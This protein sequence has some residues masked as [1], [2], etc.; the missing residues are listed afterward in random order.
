MQSQAIIGHAAP[1]LEISAWVQGEAT[2]LHDLHGKVVLVEV[3]Q[4][5]CTG[6]FVH[7]LPEV[8]HLHKTY[9]QQGLHV[10]GLATAFENFDINTLENLKRLVKTG[11]LTG[12]PLRQLGAAGQLQGDKLDYA[13]PFPIAMDLLSENRETV[14]D[15]AIQRFIDSQLADYADLP[16]DR[17][18]LIWTRASDY[19]HS[20][21]HHAHT[22]E[23][24]G[25]QG[26]PSS[27]VID[28]KGVLRNVS[29]GR[30][31]HL[32]ALIMPL[33]NA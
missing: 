27:I 23:R 24:Y 7:A 16:A 30:A 32:E 21:S 22:F 28:R 6:C 13:L 4:L 31:D 11:E 15:E 29:F 12:E 20:K 2:R 9:A 18:Q 5:N 33:L 17:Q 8:V 19:L 10:I 26:T 3:F 25:L 1:E 14:T